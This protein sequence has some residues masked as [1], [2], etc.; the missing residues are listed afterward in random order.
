MQRLLMYISV[1]V[2][3]CFFAAC[4]KDTVKDEGFVKV[5]NDFV[6]FGKTTKTSDHGFLVISTDNV[7]DNRRYAIKANDEG[8]VSWKA[9]LDYNSSSDESRTVTK[10]FVNITETPDNMALVLVEEL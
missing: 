7:Y 1:L 5:Y 10:T 4:Q 2:F 6:I 8:E 9:F 3:G